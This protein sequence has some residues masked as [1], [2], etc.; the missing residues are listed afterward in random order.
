MSKDND[1]IFLSCLGLIGIL[2]FAPIIWSL[3]AVQP[4]DWFMVPLGAP[5]IGYVHMVGVKFVVE[6]FYPSTLWIA[7]RTPETS[8][9]VGAVFSPFIM[10]AFGGLVHWVM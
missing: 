9:I 6:L 4:W 1:D 2:V 10:L 3:V 8:E 7:K 5:V